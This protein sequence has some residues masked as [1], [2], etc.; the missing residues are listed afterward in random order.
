[1]KSVR[2]VL[3]LAVALLIAGSALA[4]EKRKGKAA[5]KPPAPAIEALRMIEKLDLTADQKAKIEEIRKECGP[6]VA[7][8]QK[9]LDEILTAEQRRARAE[10]AKEAKAAGKKGKEA[11]QAVDEAMKLT[12]EQKDKMAEARKAMAA[13]QKEIRGKVMDLLTAEQ[14]ENLK[15]AQKGGKKADK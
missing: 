2:T 5:K 15:K 11:Q 10:A 14:K 7:E 13:L 12:D 1:M 4:A 8:A 3:T 9:K 6:K